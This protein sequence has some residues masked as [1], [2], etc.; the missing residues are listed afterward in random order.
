MLDG[1][2][3][4]DHVHLIKLCAND[5]RLQ[6]GVHRLDR[7]FLPKGLLVHLN[8]ALQEGRV[9]VGLPRGILTVGTAPRSGQRRNG[10]DPC[11]L[12]FELTGNGA[13][14]TQ[15]ELDGPLLG[16]DRR[17]VA[18]RFTK[19]SMSSEDFHTPC[20]RASRSCHTR[21]EVSRLITCLASSVARSQVS[22]TS[23]SR[24]LSSAPQV[25]L[26]AVNEPFDGVFLARREYNCCRGVPGNGV[27]RAP[28]RKR[29]Q[30]APP[31]A[32]RPCAERAPEWSWRC[33][34]FSGISIPEWP[35]RSPDTFRVYTA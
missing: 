7:R 8:A 28:H 33:P 16:G 2:T 3:E 11:M 1:R 10:I 13:S 12:R 24:A 17:K 6:P 27:V 31:L 4:R 32:A 29:W 22:V 19:P 20:G 34:G 15:E 23:G 18:R 14:L 5:S 26:Q 21:W 25:V 35:P 30:C 9:H